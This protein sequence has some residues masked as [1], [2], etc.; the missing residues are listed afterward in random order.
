MP[1]RRSRS[2]APGNRNRKPPENEVPLN[3]N[4]AGSTRGSKENTQFSKRIFCVVEEKNRRDLQFDQ[5]KYYPFLNVYFPKDKADEFES[6]FKQFQ[7]AKKEKCGAEPQRLFQPPEKCFGGKPL[8]LTIKKSEHAVLRHWD[9]ED[10]NNL[11]IC[12]FVSPPTEYQLD[13]YTTRILESLGYKDD[14]QIKATLRNYLTLSDSE[15]MKFIPEHDKEE[16]LKIKYEWDST[17]TSAMINKFMSNAH[18]NT[19]LLIRYRAFLFEDFLSN[20]LQNFTGY[21]FQETK[22]P[23]SSTPVYRLSLLCY[24]ISISAE[25]SLVGF[26]TIPLFNKVLKV[27]SENEYGQVRENDCW[28]ITTTYINHFN[29]VNEF[30]RTLI[31]RLID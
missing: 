27:E 6:I 19:K 2:L 10:S 21:I 1:L 13:E 31:L 22:V 23:G 12:K 8:V 17:K 5:Y 28:L 25:E 7:N 3:R 30:D 16:L 18:K 26:L 24:V 29:F 20:A 11:P 9:M 15:W 4:R 14:P